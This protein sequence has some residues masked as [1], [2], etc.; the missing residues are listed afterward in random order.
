[1][2]AGPQVRKPTL[3]RGGLD[4]SARKFYARWANPARFLRAKCGAGQPALPPLMTSAPRFRVFLT[5]LLEG[6][7]QMTLLRLSLLLPKSLSPI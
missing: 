3:M 7:S 5:H 2:R 1:M 4:K 6:F